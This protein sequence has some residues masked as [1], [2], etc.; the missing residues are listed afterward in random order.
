MLGVSRQRVTQLAGSYTDFPAPEAELAAGRIWSRTDV[1]RWIRDHPSRPGGRPV[2]DPGPAAR[3]VFDRLDDAG[4]QSVVLAQE[5]ARLRGHP[6]IG[7]EHLLIG[8]AAEPLGVAGRVLMSVGANS[9][10]LADVLESVAPARPERARGYLPFTDHSKQALELSYRESLKLNSDVI[11]TE[12]VLL[13][14]LADELNLA[15]QLLDKVNIS[16]VKLRQTVMDALGED[17]GRVDRPDY[18]ASILQPQQE[19]LNPSR[20]LVA[21]L[22]RLAQATERLDQRLGQIENS[23]AALAEEATTETNVCKAARPR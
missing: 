11:R 20:D 19:T 21:A 12:H 22:D 14:L 10:A 13:G 3:S 8:L 4:L 23:V 9:T 5:H 17:S 18:P 6:R 7:C 1:E 15:V 2:A 16:P